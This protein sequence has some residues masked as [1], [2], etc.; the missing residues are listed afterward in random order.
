M[1]QAAGLAARMPARKRGGRK[2]PCLGFVPS[3]TARHEMAAADVIRQRTSLRSAAPWQQTAAANPNRTHRQP[4]RKDRRRTFETPEAQSRSFHSAK[5]ASKEQ[6]GPRCKIWPFGMPN[7]YRKNA[8][9]GDFA[10]YKPSVAE[11][12]RQKPRSHERHLSCELFS[13]VFLS[14]SPFFRCEF[15]IERALSEHAAERSKRHRG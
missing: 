7:T 13:A 10:V 12:H 8:P 11:S 15:G 14:L 3:D 2:V 9:A 4:W 5:F 1:R 6:R